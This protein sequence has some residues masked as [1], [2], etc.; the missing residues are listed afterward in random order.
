MD[1]QNEENVVE[2]NNE[3]NSNGAASTISVERP[4]A[5][6]NQLAE[7]FANAAERNRVSDLDRISAL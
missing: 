7:M 2:N 4:P 3:A 1:Q 5:W 6:L